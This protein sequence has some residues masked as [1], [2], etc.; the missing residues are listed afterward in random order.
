MIA[1]V[2]TSLNKLELAKGESFKQSK[3]SY[4]QYAQAHLREL[5]IRV[6]PST[7]TKLG[8]LQ[9]TEIGLQSACELCHNHL[10]L[11][12]RAMLAS[13]MLPQQYKA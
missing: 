5:S 7:R 12:C 1:K 6:I 2:Q 10:E 13:N 8:Y 11:M 9:V 4:L 3:T